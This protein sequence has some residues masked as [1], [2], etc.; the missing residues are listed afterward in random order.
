MPHNAG[1]GAGTK[2]A[3]AGPLGPLSWAFHSPRRLASVVG[4]GVLALVL[5]VGAVSQAVA[6]DRGGA[7]PVAATAPPPAGSTIATGPGEGPAGAAEV[8]DTE[9]AG[10]A[11]A[12]TDASASAY[13]P[14][15]ADGE[16]ARVA[17]KFVA[18]W[19]KGPAAES[20]KT[21]HAAMRP[22]VTTELLAGLKRSDRGRVPAAKLSPAAPAVRAL[23]EYVNELTVHLADGRGIDVTLAYDGM[24][25]RVADLATTQP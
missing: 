12:G 19:L 22:Y 2:R 13:G 8:V 16:A 21:W 10:D 15:I 5:G 3:S 25:W 7:G 9:I 17:R 1:E 20:A 11:A 23:G 4:G 18:A 24:V 6:P 14:T